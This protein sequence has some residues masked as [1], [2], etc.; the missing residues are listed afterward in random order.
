MSFGFSIGDFL[1]GASL[2]YKLS[3]SL[4]SATGS[5]KDYKDLIAELHV[6]HKVLLQ[7][8]DLRVSNQLAQATLNSRL[9]ITNSATEAMEAFVHSI[10]PYRTSLS[11]SGSGNV[12][13]DAWK[14]GKWA[15]QMPVQV[16][17]FSSL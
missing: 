9:F 16:T 15:L 5:E 8:E 2:A 7:V 10:E 3:Q 12:A 17:P 6:V 11:G 4:S 13:K 1:A 14:K